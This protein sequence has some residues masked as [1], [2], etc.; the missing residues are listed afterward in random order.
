MPRGSG[1]R[2]PPSSTSSVS[3]AQAAPLSWDCVPN[4]DQRVVRRI[5]EMVWAH[6]LDSVPIVLEATGS[7]RRVV[8]MSYVRVYASPDGESHFEDVVVAMVPTEVFP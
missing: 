3:S 2:R 5:S 1:W 4:L 7:Q 8:A 6:S